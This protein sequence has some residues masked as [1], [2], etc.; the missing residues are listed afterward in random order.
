[1]PTLVLAGDKDRLI[2]KE[3]SDRL[4]EL[5]T[6]EGAELLDHVVVPEAGHMVPLEKPDAVT[7]AIVRLIRRVTAGRAAS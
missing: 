4:V 3:H 6:A 2:P 7:G 1:V 5:L